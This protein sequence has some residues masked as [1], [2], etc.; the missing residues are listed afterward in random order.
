[1]VFDG[2]DCSSKLSV[3]LSAIVVLLWE[4]GMVVVQQ[5]KPASPT[6]GLAWVRVLCSVLAA[7]AAVGVVLALFSDPD[8]PYYQW[9]ARL[10]LEPMFQYFAASGAEMG[11][12]H[13]DDH[14]LITATENGRVVMISGELLSDGLGVI[15]LLVL[16]TGF[17]TILAVRR[18]RMGWVTGVVLVILA[19]GLSLAG[20]LVA[21]PFFQGLSLAASSD[22]SV[23]AFLLRIVHEGMP[24]LL[25]A[26]VALSWLA[27]RWV[28]VEEMP[29]MTRGGRPPVMWAALATMVVLGGISVLAAVGAV[30]MARHLVPADGASTGGNAA[31]GWRIGRLAVCAFSYAA[32][33]IWLLVAVIRGRPPPW[34]WTAPLPLLA[35]LAPAAG[36]VAFLLAVLSGGTDRTPLHTASRRDSRTRPPPPRRLKSVLRTPPPSDDRRD[37]DPTVGKI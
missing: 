24:T 6:C 27:A 16:V 10:W 4:T 34:A 21:C 18:W 20:M 15:P 14:G 8:L 26:M 25:C 37:A 35:V 22:A 5:A 17:T 29:K 28:F 9:H 12:L 19:A 31:A 33:G 7:L 2:S 1:M 36:G 30:A 3:N 23:M 32:A 13:V 11:G